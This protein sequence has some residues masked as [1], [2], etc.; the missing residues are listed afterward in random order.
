MQHIKKNSTAF[1]GLNLLA[2]VLE[3]LIDL[4]DIFIP[5]IQ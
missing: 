2:R 3:D 4:Q 5:N 1:Y